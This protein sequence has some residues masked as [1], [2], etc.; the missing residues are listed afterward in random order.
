MITLKNAFKIPVG[1]S[2][3]TLGVEVAVA[4]VAMG[5]E[6]I[7][8]HFT[9]DKNMEGPDHRAS[10][11][12]DELKLIVNSI[13][14]IEK[15]MGNGIKSCGEN[16]KNTKLIARKTIVAKYNIKKGEIL[17]Y[18]NIVFKRPESGLKPVCVDLI[19][20]KKLTKDLNKDDI[21]TFEI[22]E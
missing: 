8:K 1:Y 12:P 11:N 14:N 13:R 9:L 3:H 5:A 18:D 6:I 21:I 7:E 10:L 16:E 20:G 22:I 19:L 4:A 2:D 17:S 15:A